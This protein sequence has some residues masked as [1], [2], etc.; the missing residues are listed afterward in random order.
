MLPAVSAPVLLVPTQLQLQ[1]ELIHS[2][3]WYNLKT[4]S[5]AG[6]TAVRSPPPSCF[7]I[8]TK[9]MVHSFRNIQWGWGRDRGPGTSSPPPTSVY[10]KLP[11]FSGDGGGCD[12]GPG[13]QNGCPAVTARCSDNK[14]TSHNHCLVSFVVRRKE[15]EKANTLRRS[16]TLMFDALFIFCCWKFNFKSTAKGKRLMFSHLWQ[17]AP[18]AHEISRLLSSGGGHN[19]S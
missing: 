16:H 11:T 18:S 14:W 3:G 15:T 9:W 17:N 2:V 7:R 10:C 8:G 4:R 6:A 1:K 19:E 13:T 12:R 5:S